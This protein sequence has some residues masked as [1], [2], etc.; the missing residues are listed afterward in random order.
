M[1]IEIKHR[2]TCQ[3]ICTGQTVRA[4]VQANMN[5]LRG[6]DLRG[7][8]L[9]DAY[10]QDA[11]LRGAYLQDAD[12]QGADL[13]G[14]DLQD[15][16]LQGADLRGA[17]LQGACLRGADLRGAYLRGV[18][19]RG[20]C[21]RGADLRG[22]YLRGADLRGADLGF[23]SHDLIA[24]ILRRAAGDDMAKLK[25]AGYILICRDQCW[26]DFLKLRDPLSGWAMDE[27]V[28]WV[29]DGDNAPRQL[30]E[31][32]AKLDKAASKVSA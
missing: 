28:K 6:A 21:L 24:E 18:D 17:D 30:R 9:Q 2:I 5:N 3:V 25:V 15:A 10:L 16:Y 4:A 12:L 26:S 22:A 14:A 1:P 32:K 7:A 11:Y 13:Q 8:D 20:A 29:V 19:L 23:T 27:L 31:H